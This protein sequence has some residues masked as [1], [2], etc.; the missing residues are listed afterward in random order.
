MRQASAL[1]ARPNR[2]NYKVV[3]SFGAAPDGQE[4]EASLIDVGGTLYGTTQSG[5]GCHY[6][7]PCGTVYSVSTS[8]A[9]K[10]LYSFA[11]PPDGM[12][13]LAG[14]ID[15]GGTLYGTTSG[16]GSYQCGFPCGTV[17]SVTPSG[18]EKVLHSF[19]NI[20]DGEDP[21]APLI[22]AK[23]MLYGTTQIG[24]AF[25]GG[26]V[27]SITPGGT[28]KVLYSFAYG[29]DGYWPGASLI[30]VRGMLYGTTHNGGK[31]HRC[32]FGCGTVFS[33]TQGGKEKVLHRFGVGSDGAFPSA[34]IDV[35]GTLY[36]T[37][38]AGGAY[39]GG[40]A[41]SVTPS[42]TEKVLHSFSGRSDGAGPV[43]PLINVKG[44]LYGTTEYGDA[45]CSGGCGTVFSLTPSGTEKVLHSF[46]SGADG[47]HPVAALTN[48][49]GRLYGTTTGGGTHNHGTVFAL[50]P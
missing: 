34:L 10:V 39:G 24:G 25:D 14:L 44:T 41:F 43:A 5:G 30:E 49:D 29:P 32:T 35:G 22:D 42:G 3:Y 37:T 50:K 45:Y 15:V 6:T 47:V 8:G 23:G 28:E 4:P 2:T 9:E 26:T 11:G 13:P 46:G 36:G 33:I 12:Y 48:V 18:R 40:T 7:I 38:S 31:Y 17:F 27:F 19:G 21:L 16:G 1:G 20:P